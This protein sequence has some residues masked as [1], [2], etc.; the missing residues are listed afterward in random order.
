MRYPLKTGLQ[1]AKL[2][3]LWNKIQ[4]ALNLN[5]KFLLLNLRYIYLLSR[6]SFFL[7]ANLYAHIKTV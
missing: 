2:F 6:L 3:I 5:M 1:F 4:L 7:H